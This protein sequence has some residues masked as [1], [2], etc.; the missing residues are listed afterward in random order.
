MAAV[1]SRR[2]FCALMAGGLWAS[3]VGCAQTGTP[4]PAPGP[5][6]RA[7][8]VRVGVIYP[9][10]GTIASVG[11]NCK[12]AVELAAEIVNGRFDLELPLAREEGLPNLGGARVE[13]L[14][15]DSQGSPEKGQAEA[16][17]LIT[18]EKVVALI[19][20]YQS[21]VTATASQ[22]AERL[23]I[24][25]VNADSSAVSLTERGFKWFFRTGPHDGTFVTNLFAMLQDLERARGIRVKTIGIVHD[26]TL[27]GVD[28]AKNTREAAGKY[29]YEVAVQISHPTNTTDVTSE[30]QKLK[31]AG[32]DVV[33][34][35]SYTSDAVL[36]IRTYKQLDYNPQMI[37]G[38]GSGF[39]DP[40]YTRL[41][42]RDGD[43]VISKAAWAPDIGQRK[44]AARVIAETF[45]NRFG[46]PMT[47]DSARSFTAFLVLAD[48]INRAGS[49]DP[50][51]IRRA[52]LATDMPGEQTIM[53]WKG[54]KF[55]EKT[56][57]NIY[58]QS[59][60]IQLI[61]GQYYT[62][63]PFDLATREVVWPM[64]KWSQ[65]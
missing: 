22:V 63:W 27:A 34:Q 44:P 23:G 60:N 25:F 8:P 51:A 5:G 59:V 16:E 40:Q 54:V 58:A 7:G 24:P 49:T 30:V 31:A 64:P 37:L 61:G 52:L 46:Q 45:Q 55:D 36:F 26:N 17:R 10:T 48:A 21:A 39:V 62:V 6:R 65:R 3:L 4:A 28:F 43:F 15:A 2:R 18:Q 32:P 20:A 33:F 42:G 29:G 12:Y 41:L 9:L 53:P 35:L 19:G 11:V 57:Q 14:F 56:H 47:E 50:E 38:Y 1:V 13:L